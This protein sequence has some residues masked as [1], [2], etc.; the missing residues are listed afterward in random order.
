MGT[1]PIAAGK[2]I[3]HPRAAIFTVRVINV[4][5]QNCNQADIH[6]ASPLPHINLNVLEDWFV[7]FCHGQ[8]FTRV[9][10]ST[11]Q[12][13]VVWRLTRSGWQATLQ[14]G[15]WAR[16]WCRQAF[17]RGQCRCLRCLRRGDSLI[18]LHRIHVRCLSPLSHFS[19]SAL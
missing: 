14:T 15:S 7:R 10:E 6:G 16:Y 5:S 3:H 2:T 1:S 11:V 19:R 4:S 18:L 13:H 12:R 8:R 9:K 17:L